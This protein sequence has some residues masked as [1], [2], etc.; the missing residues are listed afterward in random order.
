[1][2]SVRFSLSRA[3]SSRMLYSFSDESLLWSAACGGNRGPNAWAREWCGIV[4]RR[5]T[6][7]TNDARSGH[8]DLTRWY[9]VTNLGGGGDGDNNDD[10]DNE[11]DDEMR[12]RIDRTRFLHDLLAGISSWRWWPSFFEVVVAS[13]TEI[14]ER[15]L[16]DDDK[17]ED[18]GIWWWRLWSGHVA[19]H[20]LVW[21]VAIHAHSYVRLARY[22]RL[23][24]LV[25]TQK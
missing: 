23:F 3:I 6:K 10:N 8:D 2:L 7:K 21:A 11:N 19:T 15:E 1:M 13:L 24:I 9:M 22:L 20:P 12:W 4:S 5:Q 17:N 16:D 14:H 25:C 18:E